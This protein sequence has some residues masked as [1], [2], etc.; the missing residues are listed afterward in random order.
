M[1]RWQAL[2]FIVLCLAVVAL[3]I[4]VLVQFRTYHRKIRAMDSIMINQQERGRLA[5]E[6]GDCVMLIKLLDGSAM[7]AAERAAGELLSSNPD[8]FAL[9]RA[10]A[11]RELVSQAY[12]VAERV[13]P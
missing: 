1:T 8:A 3:S 2:A 9:E 7:L 10:R 5:V 12:G 13:E 6:R 11:F 4:V